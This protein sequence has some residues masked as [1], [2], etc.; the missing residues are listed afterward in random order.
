M[1]RT[2]TQVITNLNPNSRSNPHPD[3]NRYTVCAD[4][5]VNAS[6][7]RDATAEFLLTRGDY[8]WIGYTW[9]GCFP[10]PVHNPWKPN[11]LRPR[12][13]LWDRDYGGQSV[14]PT[15]IL[16]LILTPTLTQQVGQTDRVEK[17]GTGQASS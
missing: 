17:P 14:T 4:E 2:S 15:L 3:L 10:M 6:V 9:A 7:A 12:P 16:T 1:W 13:T 5:M 11:W 8:A